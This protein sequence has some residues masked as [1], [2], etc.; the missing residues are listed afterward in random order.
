MNALTHF[1]SNS[2]LRGSRATYLLA[3]LLA[4]VGSV[5]PVAA[6]GIV[7]D[8]RPRVRPPSALSGWA[9][10]EEGEKLLERIDIPEAPI[11]SPEQAKASFTLA[12][13]YRIE[14]VAHE[15]AVQKPIFF[16]FDPEGRMWVVEYQG[17]M[18]DLAGTDEGAP[19]CRVVVLEDKD[20]DGYAETSTVFQDGLV[21]PRSLTFVK[22]GVLIQEPPHIWFCEDLDGDLKADRK[23]KVGEMGFPGNP[24]HTA[25]GLRYGLDNWLH[26]ADSPSRYRWR[27]GVLEEAPTVKRGQFGV[28]FDD[29]GRFFT[30]YQDQP[31][32]G[33]YLPAEYLLRNPHFQTLYDN[34]AKDKSRFGV[35]ADLAPGDANL[36]Y[37][38]RVTPAITLGA[39]ELRDDGRL[40]TYTIVAGTCYYD[41][42][43]FPDDAY[44]NFFV[45]ESGGHLL[46]RLV[47]ENGIK[48]TV[49]RY[50][51]AEQEFL[52]STD[53]RFRPVNARVGPD[54]A[55]Y[56]ADMYHGII[57]HVIFMVPW[58]EKQINE[59]KLAEGDDFGRMWRIVAEDRP[60][61]RVPP[62][63]NAMTSPEL[64]AMLGHANGWQRLTA[65][66]L[67][68][69]RADATA[70]LRAYVQRAH[71][72]GKV[73]ALWSLDGMGALDNA[74]RRSALRDAD[75]VVREM[76]V[77][78]SEGV[79]AL[80]AEVADL[81]ADTSPAVRLQ[82][83]LSL[84]SYGTPAARAAMQRLLEID[85]EPL[86]GTAALTG[87][88]G[89]E[90]ET[91]LE[92]QDQKP[93]LSAMLALCVLY[94]GDE[95]RVDQL[96]G[97][98]DDSDARREAIL[99]A[100]TWV[101]WEAPF[102]LP[103]RPT[104]LLSLSRDETLPEGQRNRALEALQKLEWPGAER[105]FLDE[106]QLAAITDEQRELIR[107]GEEKFN[108][109]C[110]ACH[111]GHGRGLE[112]V[113]PPL[114]GSEWVT[115]SEERAARIVLNGLYGEIEVAGTTWNLAM[116]GFANGG[117]SDEDFAGILSYIRQA[118]G[119]RA[120]P[121]DPA[122]IASVRA[123][124][125]DRVMP[126]RAG[127]LLEND[128]AE[129]AGVLIEPATDGSLLLPASKSTVFG[130]KLAYREALDVLAPW[131]FVEDVAEWKVSVAN[132]GS[133]RVL[134]TL[135]ADQ[136]S[137]GNQFA[138]VASHDTLIGTVP[139]TGSYTTFAEHDAGV[140]KLTA[141]ESRIVMQPHGKLRRELADVRG[142]KL[143]PVDAP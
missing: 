142:L 87:L 58:L 55:L 60:L 25:N 51:P 121:V 19:I 133:Y 65:Q 40:E 77:R 4:L 112:G 30:C 72:L 13:G 61:S 47:M 80:F 2:S 92:W 124:S 57:E 90:L 20:H 75:P 139:D 14:L 93:G 54:G 111:Q 106:D 136:V 71:G 85:A 126:W 115:G 45:P 49:S 53:E 117:F 99:N 5:V 127:E 15:P 9:D 42:T 63:L 91:F 116:P 128:E 74:S 35:N 84:G 52:Q 10:W 109:I 1:C 101:Q 68:V 56:I 3:G 79:A 134:V 73:H 23:T 83:M 41:G 95:T 138:V 103:V 11:L 7:P 64:V 70:E 135:A 97:H 120:P 22:G 6:Q 110:A 130:R 104:A 98:L 29:K 125:V 102:R 81:V 36:V 18:R 67:L 118:W 66:R 59:R 76:G 123:A 137:A 132:A 114:A 78:L 8:G 143:V 39:L 122:T 44:G 86:L 82:L 33:D 12:P 140:L 131:R 28:T 89:Q 38:N 141:G 27:D 88:G 26:C 129:T 48:P 107:H 16:E 17:Y 96:L 105:R 34:A 113:A 108:Q 32:Y 43:Q 24:Q 31:L 62:N 46:G 69:E 21:M 37:P 94:E 100:L 50:Y 119:N